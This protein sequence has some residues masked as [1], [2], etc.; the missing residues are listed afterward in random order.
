MNV[1]PFVTGKSS[2]VNSVSPAVTSRWWIQYQWFSPVELQVSLTPPSLWA[3]AVRFAGAA[4][5][6]HL[7]VTLTAADLA[8]SRLN[9]LTEL[10]ANSYTCPL[11]SSPGWA[12]VP[13]V[14]GYSRR[15]NAA[16]AVTSRW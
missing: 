10:T 3:V 13:L 15:W 1:V 7:A 12:E 16:P 6:S 9:L 2:L 4:G 11:V 5:L 14:T 8:D